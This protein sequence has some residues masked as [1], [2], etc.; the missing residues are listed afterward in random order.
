MIMN[1]EGDVV[2]SLVPIPFGNNM[3]AISDPEAPMRGGMYM[4][5]PYA[6]GPIWAYVPGERVM[7]ILDR[8]APAEERGSYR[9]TKV[10]FNRDTLF[11]R[12]YA[13]T[14]SPI[15]A[16]EADSILDATAE[17]ISGTRFMGGL[18]LGTARAWAATGMYRPSHYP[19]VTHM[20]LSQSGEIWL[21]ER[22]EGDDAPWLVLDREGEPRWRTTLPAG[23]TVLLADGDQV[24]GTDR[25][26]LDVPYLVG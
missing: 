19:P 14:A 15:P 2:D 12:T 10:D 8:E 21:R 20:V 13:F 16:T 18:P 24:W 17:R 5:Q 23:V 9:L 7:L 26:E 4:P 11:S 6:D 3:W 25:D 22:P 1:R